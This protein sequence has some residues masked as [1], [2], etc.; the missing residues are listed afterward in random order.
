MNERLLSV[1]TDSSH[2]ADTLQWESEKTWVFR[3]AQPWWHTWT[4]VADFCCAT[5]LRDFCC[6]S[7]MG[8]C[9]LRNPN[10][11]SNLLYLCNKLRKNAQRWLVNYCLFTFRFVTMLWYVPCFSRCSIHRLVQLFCLRLLAF[12]FFLHSLTKAA[13][14][15]TPEIKIASSSVSLKPRLLRVLLQLHFGVVADRFLLL[16]QVAQ[17]KSATKVY[18]CVTRGTGLHNTFTCAQ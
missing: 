9:K 16:Q 1:Q 8:C 2:C 18:T 12:A 15:N 5:L 7:G 3:R 10:L 11:N 13:D 17:Q 14:N 6:T 4:F